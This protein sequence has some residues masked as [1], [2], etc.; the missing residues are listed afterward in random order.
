VRDDHKREL[1]TR[2]LE[3]ANRDD[4]EGAMALLKE[5]DRYLGPEEA[6]RLAEVA[7]GVVAG[8]RE[9]LGVQFKL[10]VNDHRW[11][12]AARTGEAIIEEFPN[13]KMAD[14]VR[15]M[16]DVLRTRATQSAVA[17]EGA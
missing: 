9:N 11:A 2:F 8:H 4:V 14:E 5:L 10:A 13:T 6:E 12:E 17:G 15:S 7:Q 1:E 3:A 16:I